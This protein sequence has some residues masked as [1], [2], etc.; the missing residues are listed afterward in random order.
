[1]QVD[2]HCSRDRVLRDALECP[3]VAAADD[4]RGERVVRFP[5][6]QAPMGL[7]CVGEQR[8]HVGSFRR[9]PW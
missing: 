2:P 7:D 9:S 3:K 8:D 6:V 5:A 4:G 1:M